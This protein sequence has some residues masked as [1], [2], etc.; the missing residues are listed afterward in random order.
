MLLIKHLKGEGVRVNFISFFLG[1]SDPVM[2]NSDLEPQPWC[3]VKCY[4][5]VRFGV[6][7]KRRHFY[8]V[9]V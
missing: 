7:Q 4:I 2:V 1:L 5:G 6:E 3:W 9:I 8:I